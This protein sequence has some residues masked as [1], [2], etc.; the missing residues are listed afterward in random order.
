MVLSSV[1]FSLFCCRTFIFHASRLSSVSPHP[2]Q[3]RSPL[4]WELL[5]CTVRGLRVADRR[6][7]T[8]DTHLLPLMT[9]INLGHC[10]ASLSAHSQAPRVLL[11][12]SLAASLPSPDDSH[13]LWNVHLNYARAVLVPHSCE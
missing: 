2:L 12:C 6:Q 13:S 8:A 1:E 4:R 5:P 11:P 9:K 10:A 3:I 7:P